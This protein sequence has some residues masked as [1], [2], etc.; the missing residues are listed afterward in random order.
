MA[1]ETRRSTIERYKYGMCINDECPKCKSKEIQ[2][3]PI[4]KE[5]VC[6]ECGKE[7]RECPP[8]KKAKKKKFII[9]ALIIIAF[10]I[11]AGCIFAFS[12]SITEDLQSV[13]TDSI[14]AIDT[15]E[16]KADTVVRTDTVVVRDTIVKNN[17]VTTNEKV[18]TKTVV[19]TTAPSQPKSASSGNGTIRLS[20]GKYS[21]ATKNG[22]PHGQGRLTY[23]STRVIN[24]N[25][26]KGRTA[27]AGDYVIGEF[28]NGFLV[29]G[30]HY[31]AAGNLLEFLN[32]GVGNESS[33]ESK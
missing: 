23:T 1:K 17:I 16:A 19:N 18:T 27:N 2:Q 24:R 28:H 8:P 7:L 32:I 12:G 15:A 9:G 26:P 6:E 30:K 25:D 3:I 29:Y 10:A 4:R 14:S 21:G 31:D 13:V 33:Y 22:Y 5:L 11:I 20:Y